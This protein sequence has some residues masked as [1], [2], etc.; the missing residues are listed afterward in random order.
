[1]TEDLLVDVADKVATVTLNRPAVLNA[2]TMPM[3]HA[4]CRLLAALDADPA[5]RAIV[6]TG[7]GRGFCAGADLEGG[8]DFAASVLASMDAGADEPLDAPLLMTTPTIAAINGPCA[9]MGTSYALMCDVRYASSGARIGTTFARLGLVA[10]WGMAHTLVGVVGQSAAADLLLSAR[11]VQADEALSIGLVTRVLPAQ[12]L[13]P[14]AR[15]WALS[16]AQSSP[17]STAAIKAQLRR[18]AD[19]ESRSDG[20]TRSVALMRESLGWP[21]VTAAVAAFHDKR[22]PTFPDF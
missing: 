7:A 19:G 12:E 9:G 10:E 13:L 4:Y 17:R 2:M 22:E 21:D 15:A 6:V 5:V 14:A 8:P 18:V 16:V 11:Y 1:M 20:F 3:H